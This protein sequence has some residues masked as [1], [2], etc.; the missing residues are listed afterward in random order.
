M[1]IEI[2]TSE[3]WPD[4]M[5]RELNRWLQDNED[6]KVIDIK[7]SI[8]ASVSNHKYSETHK[9]VFSALVMYVK[10]D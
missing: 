8:G 10:K 9:S 2:F 6:I 5:Q 3:D 4:V 1:Q 7:Y